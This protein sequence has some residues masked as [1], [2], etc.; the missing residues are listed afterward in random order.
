MVHVDNDEG[1]TMN[2]SEKILALISKEMP[3]TPT[4]L[5][6]GE[7]TALGSEIIRCLME[8]GLSVDEA[9]ALTFAYRS[10]VWNQG[11]DCGESGGR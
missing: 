2:L 5:T 8:A 1:E 7:T 6:T 10:A 4:T 3:E 11:Y 9:V